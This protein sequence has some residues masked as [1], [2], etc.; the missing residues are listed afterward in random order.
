MRLANATLLRYRYVT[1]SSNGTDV[2]PH[3]QQLLRR[4]T[5]AKTQATLKEMEQL[6]IGIWKELEEVI[7][8]IKAN[9]YVRGRLPRTILLDDQTLN[10][11][12][13][14]L[15]CAEESLYALIRP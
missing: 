6:H 3:I 1:S 10:V 15:E 2:I 11:H 4:T 12:P 8:Q 13:G 9:K 5:D 14:D 7:D